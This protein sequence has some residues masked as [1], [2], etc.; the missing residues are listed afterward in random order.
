MNLL[1]A[2]D[3]ICI[4]YN[5]RICEIYRDSKLTYG[6][7]KKYSDA[8]S[9]YII[10]K[11]GK[12][13]SPIVIYGHKEHE[14]LIS[15]LAC[16]KSGHAYI[17]ID[18]TFPKDRINDII[19]SSSPKLFINIGNINIDKF[20][21]E[22]LLQQDLKYIFNKFSSSKFDESFYIKEND[23]YYM[24][25]TS[26][27]T[28]KPKGVQI[29][30]KALK[31][32]IEWFMPYCKTREDESVFLNQVSYSFDV[33]VISVYIGLLLGKTLYVIDKE[34]TSNFKDLF[35]NLNIS[36]IAMWISTPSF[37][38]MCVIDNS[39]NKLLL[40]K[41]EKMFFAG[42]VLS[43][44]LVSTLYERFDNIS[45]IN[46]YGPT[47]TTVL[48]TAIEINKNMLHSE[49][50]IPI[51]YSMNNSKIMLVDD[52]GMEIKNGE[53][54]EVYIIGDNVSIGYYKNEEM[55]KK[56][57]FTIESSEGVKF[58]YKTGDLAYKKDGIFYY[59]GRKDFQIK[60]NGFRI[61]LED[62]ENNLRKLDYVSNDVV[63]P[64]KHNEKISY[65]AALVKLNKSIDEKEF[66]IAM[67]IKNDLG[68]LLPTY[69]I[70]RKI[71]LVDKFPIN[72]NGKIDRKALQEDLK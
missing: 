49:E 54:G 48:V 63:L 25:Y 11:Y 15:F 68:K 60:L 59:C 50:P 51:G 12:D 17:P 34:M 8:L 56:H 9:K 29:T 38:E 16:S 20:D 18:T 47:E 24:L 6:N 27:S 14:M 64:V 1:K 43:K 33:S 26:G 70:P 58:G 23:V 72:T 5:E 10:L 35:K 7:L 67:K 45:I 41:L 52:A 57:F 39:F 22:M 32:F 3:E 4:K 71:K 42:E 31:T 2:I 62:I 65:I 44:K 21:G 36:K 66:K 30:Y 55:N 37:A 53:K 40:P 13:K 46:G 61:E 19:E 69:M 28:G